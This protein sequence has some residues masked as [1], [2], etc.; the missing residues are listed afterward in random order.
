MTEELIA[1]IPA[2]EIVPPTT[3]VDERLTLQRGRR[4]IEILRLGRS[5]THG[6]LVVHLPAERVVITG[7]L[8][9]GPTPLIGADQS[10][11]GEW[12]R[13]LDR[14]MALG[15]GV[16]VPGHGAVLRDD[17]QVK[18]LRDFMAAIDRHAAAAIARGETV[19]QARASLNLDEFRAAMAGTDPMLRLLFANYGSGPGL[20][21]AFRE[22]ARTAR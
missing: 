16:Y 5:H 1:A 22:G 3:V 11:V 10:F 9:V 13:S 14:L 17:T 20:G 6:D 15:A 21:A 4:R 18:R 7:D 12:A 8:V 2:I 19:E